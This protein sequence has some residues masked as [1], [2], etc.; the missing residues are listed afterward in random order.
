MLGIKKDT[1]LR[2]VETLG[3]SIRSHLYI[4]VKIFSL[5]QTQDSLPTSEEKRNPRQPLSHLGS[6]GATV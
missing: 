2:T 1:Y 5:G 6:T 3:Q 4:G